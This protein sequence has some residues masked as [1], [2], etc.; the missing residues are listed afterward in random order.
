MSHILSITKYDLMTKSQ[1]V[2]IAFQQ[3]TLNNPHYYTQLHSINILKFS[4]LNLE[5]YSALNLLPY[6]NID[7]EI[8]REMLYIENF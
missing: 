7:F 2:Y 5:H 4:Q 1:K 8:I 3:I 6:E